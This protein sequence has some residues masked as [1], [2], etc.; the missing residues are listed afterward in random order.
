MKRSTKRG[1]S[2]LLSLLMLVTMMPL[3]NMNTWAQETDETVPDGVTYIATKEELSAVR[4]NPAGQYVLTQ[5]I[6]FTPDDFE[7]GGAFYNDGAG[8]EPIGTRDVPFTGTFDGNG[9]AIQGLT[10]TA[11]S[12]QNH[13]YAGLFGYVSGTVQ[14]IGRLTGTVMAENG[15]SFDAYAGGVAG[16]LDG[17]TVSGCHSDMTVTARSLDGKAYAGGVTGGMQNDSTLTACRQG[18]T[19]QAETGD[20]DY[21]YAGGI[22][23]V[24]KYGAVSVCLNTGAVMA[25]AS[26][27]GTG[28]GVSYVY[29]GGIVG[30]FSSGTAENIFNMGSV[31]ASG[32][33]SY[34]GG[35]A[36][37]SGGR[38]QNG[39]NVGQV[40]A[41]SKYYYNAYAGGIAGRVA[42]TPATHCYYLDIIDRGA[43]TSSSVCDL[44]ACTSQQMQKAE[45]FRHFDFDSVWVLQDSGYRY[46][47]LRGVEMVYEP[48]PQQLTMTRLPDKTVYVE[49][50]DSLDLTGGQITLLYNDGNT[51]VIDL[52]E[53][54]VTGFDNRI[55]GEQTLLVTYEGLTT[56]FS[57]TVKEITSLQ[58][59]SV[60][61]TNSTDGVKIS[62]KT[63]PYAQSYR[64]YRRTSSTDW[65]RLDT[66]TD[67]SYTD[68]SAKAGTTYYYTVR[69]KNGDV[70]SAYVT[71]K[72]I[73]RLTR[74]SVSLSNS[75]SGVTISWSKVTGAS[76]YIIYRRTSS[77]GWRL[78]PD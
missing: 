32:P 19:V 10:V 76:E 72:S 39:Y 40:E 50:T 7:E 47:Q 46:P 42:S 27:Q 16:L 60:S 77:T 68:T 41:K 45:T 74:P 53:D 56:T 38:L 5:D 4:E 17:G 34:T 48:A 3:G 24:M 69:A 2:W 14:D 71:D 62:W 20:Y 49:G 64:V 21:S 18:G 30:L 36:G 1:L 28:D 15:G 75:T 59:P 43:G 29:A 55:P 73:R 58:T 11:A 78:V 26:E 35:L 31:L 54:M 12:D 23:G 66:I 70:V 25:I 67:T 65:Q 9:H 52:A 44:T 6:V 33:W 61:L 51:E 22:T 63:V 57:V 8:W 37:Y 13:T